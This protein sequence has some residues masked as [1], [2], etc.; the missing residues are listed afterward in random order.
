MMA[1]KKIASLMFFVSLSLVGM[2]NDS[3]DFS[4]V[5]VQCKERRS[6]VPRKPVEKNDGFSVTAF[7]RPQRYSRI[8][9]SD[10][11]INCCSSFEYIDKLNESN[12][13][14]D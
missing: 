7:F 8:K 10:I 5:N 3:N 4:F 14:V 11:R 6:T 12:K 2:E 9:L 13:K 1:C